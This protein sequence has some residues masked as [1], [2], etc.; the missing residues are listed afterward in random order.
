MLLSL[1]L[2]YIND[3]LGNILH[4]C[5]FILNVVLS[6]YFYTSCSLSSILI[7][8]GMASFIPTWHKWESFRKREPHETM[9]LPDWPVDVSV[10]LACLLSIIIWIRMSQVHILECLNMKEWHYLKKLKGLGC[11]GLLEEL[12]HQGWALRFQQ[13]KPSPESF[14]LWIRMWLSTTTPAP[15]C[16]L[17][18]FP[19]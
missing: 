4:T 16:M 13:P 7:S 1:V 14:C 2:L 17:P 3:D 8:Y 10:M 12:Y 5:I 6:L 18:C 19:W 11:V 9:P 15:T